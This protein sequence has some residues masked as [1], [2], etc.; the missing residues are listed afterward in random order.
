MDP[1]ADG[2]NWRKYGQ[3]YVKG[4]SNPRSYYRCTEENCPVK[5]HVELQG[6]QIMNIYEGVHNHAAPSIVQE[7]GVGEIL[8]GKN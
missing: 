1:V 7:E 4:S 2:Y 3:K 6:N 5:K 8:A